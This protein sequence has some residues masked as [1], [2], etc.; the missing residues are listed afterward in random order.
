MLSATLGKNILEVTNI[1]QHGLWL[2]WDDR[3]FFLSYEN[4]PWFREA[5]VKDIL[6]VRLE[7]PDHLYWPDLD[8]DLSLSILQEPEKYPLVSK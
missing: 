6:N 2:Y 5:K 7:A 3:E 1:S 8:V 4:Y